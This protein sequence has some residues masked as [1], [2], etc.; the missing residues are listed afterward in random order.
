MESGRASNKLKV[1]I[2]YSRVD[3]EFADRL[4]DAL[5]A[6]GFDVLIDR[7]SLPVLEDWKRELLGLI[8]T[9]DTVLF[10]I[11]P[12]S[13]DS[14]M[15]G[16]EVEQV[17][18]M[19]K[20]LA[21]VVLELVDNDKIPPAITKIN[22]LFFNPPNDFELQIKLLVIALFADGNWIRDHTRLTEAARHWLE[23]GHR[24]SDLLR[25]ESLVASEQW[26][27]NR[28]QNAPQATELL[29]KFITSSRETFDRDERE[30]QDQV[31]SA[32]LFQSRF[33]VST[34]GQMLRD[35][36]ATTAAL[37]ALESFSLLELDHESDKTGALT[38]LGAAL[39]RNRERAI[40]GGEMNPIVCAKCSSDGRIFAVVQRSGHLQFLNAE[41]FEVA[42][43]PHILSDPG[44]ALALNND[45]TLAAS[46]TAAGAIR[47]VD[48]NHGLVRET[49]AHGAS[50]FHDLIFSGSGRQ[51]LA[52]HAAGAALLDVTTGEEFKL[53]SHERGGKIVDRPTIARFSVNNRRLVTAHSD[54][55]AYVWDV[56]SF[57]PLLILEG[58][59]A[60]INAVDFS[61]DGQRIATASDDQTVRLW[62]AEAGNAWEAGL[63][64]VRVR[65]VGRP[66]AVLRGHEKAVHDVTFS[67]DGLFVASASG[68]R[69]VRVWDIGRK[70]ELK[71]LPAGTAAVRKVVFSRDG[72]QLLTVS[73]DRT[74]R[75]WNVDT[76]EENAVLGGHEGSILVAA[77]CGVRSVVTQSMDGTA[78]LWAPLDQ[79]T[80][81]DESEC[82]VSPADAG[83]A[84]LYR[85]TY[86]LTRVAV[87]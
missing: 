15:C 20:R 8:R 63:N 65:D 49:A 35:G 33:L 62:P 47:L 71:R 83:A 24:P 59:G 64:F 36:D 25:G 50:E 87:Q 67:P 37:L 9:A 34:S 58:D 77:F 14:P 41:T 4:V 84:I 6:S 54:G 3:T 5:V 68:D 12:R 46:I 55:S 10:I 39:V 44:V 31:R 43:R 53:T 13:I 19:S 1:F 66:I 85:R 38:H 2:S 86:W 72:S 73:D 78:R 81:A 52:L 51:L 61:L 18:L 17:A 45:A 28:P 40:F 32:M 82:T 7:R 57:R 74:A 11:S 75:V 29:E 26:L 79:L 56:G 70:V 42:S 76:G 21:P 80:R 27:S 22:Y 60:A 48:R 23:H 30:R 69:T 16:W